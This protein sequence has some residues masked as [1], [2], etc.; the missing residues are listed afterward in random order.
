MFKFVL[1]LI[2]GLFI[3][4][5]SSSDAQQPFYTCNLQLTSSNYGASC[6]NPDLFSLPSNYPGP[7]RIEVTSSIAYPFFLCFSYGVASDPTAATNWQNGLCPHLLKIEAAG[8]RAPEN[9]CPAPPKN[10]TKGASSGYYFTSMV[11]DPFNLPT[12]A[13][14]PANFFPQSDSD[15]T[16]GYFVAGALTSLQFINPGRNCIVDVTINIFTLDPCHQANQVGTNCDTL[17]QLAPSP[18]AAVTTSDVTLQP[19][20]WAFYTFDVADELTPNFT[21]TT[22][23]TQPAGLKSNTITAYFRWAGVPYVNQTAFDQK[24]QITKFKQSITIKNPRPGQWFVA[25]TN[26]GKVA[27]SGSLG[28]F[29]GPLGCPKAGQYGSGCTKLASFDSLSLSYK[30]F[31][32]RT[33]TVASTTPSYIIFNASSSIRVSVASQALTA[34][35]VYLGAGFI[36]SADNYTLLANSGDSVNRISTYAQPGSGSITWVLAIVADLQE[37][38]GYTV[39]LDQFCADDCLDRG[40]CPDDVFNPT[41][42]CVCN[43][44]KGKTTYENFECQVANNHNFQLEYIVLIAVGGAIILSIVIGIPIYCAIHR[45]KSMQSGYTPLP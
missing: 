15:G 24:N 43:A 5:P 44:T 35:S 42:V 31:T 8:G 20:Q 9:E 34:P 18:T 40:Y 14:V 26:T 27:V 41:G 7:V 10:N 45:R 37:T 29:I 19:D 17:V 16:S 3:I 39:W 13:L 33:G 32:S 21:L 6:T 30:N 4:F 2:L 25:F 1:L 12:T 38:I 28:V 23:W 36:P 22:N 11:A